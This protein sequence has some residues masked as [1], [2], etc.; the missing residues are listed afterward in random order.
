MQKP[1]ET[2]EL[3]PGCIQ[4]GKST[5]V[6][7]RPVALEVNSFARHVA[8]LGGTGSGKTTLA[9]NLIEHL[10]LRGVPAIVVDRKGDLARYADPEAIASLLGPLG[11]LFREKVDVALYT[12]GNSEGRGLALSVL[13]SKAVGANSQHLAIQA[14]DAAGALAAML[15]YRENRA[16]QQK[17]AVLLAAIEV[18]WGLDGVE[19]TLERLLHLISSEDPALIGRMDF[20]EPRVLRDLVQD[21]DTFRKLNTRLLGA[22]AEPLEARRLFGLGE[23]ARPGRT[24]LSVISTK[25]VGDNNAVQFWVAQLMMELDRFASANP[26]A[27]LQG[28]VTLDE[29]DLYLPA[30]GKPASKQPVE[31]ALRRF[32]SQGIGIM[33]AS[34][35]PGDFD[36]RCRENIQTWFVGKVTQNTALQ[37]LRPV[38]GESGGASA[39]ARLGQH[40]TGTF[41][42]VSDGQVTKIEADRNLLKTEQLSDAKIVEAA[43]KK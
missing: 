33:L 19:P 12:P 6:Q 22:G 25:F 23:H 16:H 28:V 43:R 15:R 24:R 4:L 9:M 14:E 29:A 7:P 30:T 35:S 40:T 8:V 18:L 34:Q 17:K 32:R 3:N 26:S 37:K 13:P 11:K 2:V 42:M 31:N 41:C 21:L 38:F 5:G 27:T 1:I 39:L 36:Y 10:L 20:F